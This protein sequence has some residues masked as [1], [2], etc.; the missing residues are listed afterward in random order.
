LSL[1]LQGTV[2]AA[3]RISPN[4]CGEVCIWQRGGGRPEEDLSEWTEVLKRALD[5]PDVDWLI[6]S[7][8]SPNEAFDIEVTGGWVMLGFFVLATQSLTNGNLGALFPS[9]DT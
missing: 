4:I 8:T 7:E 5:L 9:H 6:R 2:E 1:D 3:N